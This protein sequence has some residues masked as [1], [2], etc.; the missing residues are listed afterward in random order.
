MSASAMR[1][2]VTYPADWWLLSDRELEAL[3]WGR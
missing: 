3:S 2:V 1:R